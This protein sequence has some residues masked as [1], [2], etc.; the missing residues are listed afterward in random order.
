[1]NIPVK[2]GMLLQHNGHFYFVDD[3]TERHSGQQRPSVHVSLREAMDGRHIDRT[4]DELMP[5]H[6]VAWS[7]RTLQYLYAKGKAHVFMDS[8]SFEEVELGESMLG[9][10][11]PFLKEGDEYRAVFADDRPLRL[12]V[13]DHMVLSIVDTAAPTHAVGQSASILKEAQLENGLT[14]R[15]PLFL[16]TGDRIHINTRT[17]E[18]LGKA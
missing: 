9:G 3:I 10:F 7:Y 12:E 17:R 5:V 8:Q 1:M 18:Y 11:E 16:K 6:E 15:V 2:R 14:V 13:P 4:V